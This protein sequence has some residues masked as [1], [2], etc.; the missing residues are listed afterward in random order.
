VVHTL[1]DIANIMIPLDGSIHITILNTHNQPGGLA[2]VWAASSCCC[3][4]KLFLATGGRCGHKGR[5][6]EVW[7]Q[8]EK[9]G[10]GITDAAHI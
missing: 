1:A 9:E 4:R 10:V 7:T 2:R 3:Q 6:R 5:R 8:G